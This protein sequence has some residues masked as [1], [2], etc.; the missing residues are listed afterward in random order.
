MMPSSRKGKKRERIRRPVPISFDLARKLRAAVGGRPLAAPLLLRA[1]DRP[2]QP[3]KC[4]HQKPFAKVARRAGIDATIYALRHSSIVRSLL[5]G[6]P[7][8]VVA[9]NHDTSVIQIEKTYSAFIADFSDAIA[10]RGLLDLAPS[11]SEKVVS[12]PR[13]S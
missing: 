3:A 1:D 2:W 11:S 9:A 7:T 10:R 4:D 6:V 13:R 5:A 8:R 12:L